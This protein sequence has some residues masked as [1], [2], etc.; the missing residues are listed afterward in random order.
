LDAVPGGLKT[1]KNAG[2]SISAKPDKPKTDAAGDPNADVIAELE[3]TE[4]E[5]IAH[6][7]AHKAAAGRFGG[8]A[9]Y[10]YTDG[11]DGKRY[12]TGGDVQVHTP[13]TS[14]PEEALRNASQVMRAAL[15]PGDPSGQ[16]LS[17]ASSAASMASAARAQIA[18][19]AG[20]ENESG[21]SQ[22]SRNIARSYADNLSPKGLWS[23]QF[24]YEEPEK[25][26]DMEESPNFSIAA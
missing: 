5:V 13:A 15:A 6:E 4:R 9:H 16:D 11:P 1:S 22:V 21:K 24:G 10:S 25:A 3:K 20:S 17:A 23:S 7:N 18:R 14:D 8:P 19:S 12:V 2:T 26:R